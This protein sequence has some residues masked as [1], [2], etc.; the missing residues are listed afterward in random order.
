MSKAW[1]SNEH[2]DEIVSKVQS[3]LKSKTASPKA[4][5]ELM[6]LIAGVDV[7]QISNHARQGVIKR[8]FEKEYHKVKVGNHSNFSLSFDDVINIFWE[9]V[10]KSLPDA[11]VRGST[12]NTRAVKGQPD[13][14]HQNQHARATNCNPINWLRTRGVLGVRNAINKTYNKNLVQICDECGHKSRA[15]SREV[16]TKVCPKCLSVNTLEHWPDGSSTYKSNKERICQDCG[17]TWK[18]K[19]AY[20]CA[21]CLSVCVH[22]ESIFDS[23]S[24]EL[25]E[26][27]I[28]STV[29]DEHINLEGEAEIKGIINGL[30]N[31][32]PLNPDPNSDQTNTK[33]R[34]V[35]DILFKPEVSKDICA[36]CVAKACGSNKTCGA[37]S[38]SMD[39]C[40]N[41]GLRIGEYQG[42]SSALSAR[43]IRVIRKYFIKYLADNQHNELCASTYEQL[44]ARGRL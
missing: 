31:I 24:I 15:D 21:K 13:A 1:V 32:L 12:V 28:D 38:F 14:E 40:V 9:S 29:E 20:V 23:K 4:I 19:F 33:A 34:E 22:I 37:D 41:Y 36:K 42:V 3:A 5:Y 16:N 8:V 39:K 35:L 2:A 43:R 26:V 17:A 25:C 44:K 10:F 27:S 6:S 18:R 30:Y 11:K 7:Y